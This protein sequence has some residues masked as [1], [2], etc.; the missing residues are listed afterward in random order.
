M[1][2]LQAAT[3]QLLTMAENSS[4][5]NSDFDKFMKSRDFLEILKLFDDICG[6]VGIDS[7]QYDGFFD[8]V[9]AKM[10]LSWK[11]RKL[12]ELYETKANHPVYKNQECCRG[13]RCLVIGAGPV[14]L[15]SA[16]EAA[17]LGAKVEVV[18]KRSYFSRNNVL[19]LWPF[20]VEDLRAL[21]AKSLYPQFCP[22][23][24]DHISELMHVMFIINFT[25]LGYG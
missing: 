11:C 3:S 23:G 4:T 12:W 1:L 24:I 22:G 5:A 20:L 10:N 16:I 13:M 8:E 19:H 21:G 17:L 7:H 2:F 18:E 14:G 9:K 15:R 25:C 6:K